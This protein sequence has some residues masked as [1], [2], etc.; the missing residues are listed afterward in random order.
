MIF[1]GVSHRWSRRNRGRLHAEL[2]DVE[3]ASPCSR[4][5]Q[6]D[7]VTRLAENRMA[8]RGNMGDFKSNKKSRLH[9]TFG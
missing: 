9:S 7:T 1:C 3:R 8:V 6:Y 4:L 5:A 2:V